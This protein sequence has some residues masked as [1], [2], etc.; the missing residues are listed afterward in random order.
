MTS[1]KVLAVVKDAVR[2]KSKYLCC[3]SDGSLLCHRCTRRKWKTLVR[4][5]LREA[6]DGW[7]VTGKGLPAPGE[8]CAICNRYI[9]KDKAARTAAPVQRN[10]SRWP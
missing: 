6:G 8:L 2:G 9:N 1:Y 3:L 4:S 7:Q 5:T 10:E